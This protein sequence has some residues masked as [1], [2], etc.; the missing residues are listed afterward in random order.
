MPMPS[1]DSKLR[2]MVELT[3]RCNMHGRNKS[4]E[5]LKLAACNVQNA[6][7]RSPCHCQDATSWA[8]GVRCPAYVRSRL[9]VQASSVGRFP[10]CT[11]RCM[12]SISEL[13][14]AGSKPKVNGSEAWRKKC[15]GHCMSQPAG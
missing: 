14:V 7:F 4:T 12:E 9:S 15:R 13:S 8:A 6:R 1:R 10:E 2:H 11:C 5:M 3:L